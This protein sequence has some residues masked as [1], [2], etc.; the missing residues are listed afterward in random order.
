MQLCDMN[1][2]VS[3]AEAVCRGL[4]DEVRSL[5]ETGTNPDAA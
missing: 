5:L 2:C 4:P 3:L 1:L